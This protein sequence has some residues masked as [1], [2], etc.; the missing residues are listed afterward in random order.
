MEPFYD[1]LDWQEDS[2]MLIYGSDLWATPSERFWQKTRSLFLD[3]KSLL[4]IR[5]EALFVMN[6][7]YVEESIWTEL[8]LQ[9]FSKNSTCLSFSPR[10]SVVPSQQINRWLYVEVLKWCEFCVNLD[11]YDS[12]LE[13]M[14]LIAFF[15]GF[16]TYSNTLLLALFLLLFL[17]W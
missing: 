11:I 15:A 1:L 17:W 2:R 3:V 9:Q 10:L 12:C 7:H 6:L 13:E 4:G 8:H 16:V 5:E 14:P